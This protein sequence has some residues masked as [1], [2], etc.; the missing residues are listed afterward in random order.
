MVRYTIKYL[1]YLLY[2][3]YCFGLSHYPVILLCFISL[4]LIISIFHVKF[5]L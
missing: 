1:K 2:Q 3:S 5:L 4:V